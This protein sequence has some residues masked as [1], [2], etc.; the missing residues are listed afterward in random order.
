MDRHS[1]R[2]EDLPPLPLRRVRDLDLEESTDERRSPH[3]S[4][5]SGIVRR[6]SFA[7][8][9]GDD[10]LFLA[11]FDL[12]GSE[13]GT[14]HRALEGELPSDEQERKAAK[15]DLE[16]LTA[17][18]PMEGSPHGGLLGLGSGSGEGRHRGFFWALE[19]DG[20]L[21]G[22]PVAIELEPLYERLGGEVGAVN[23][24][25]AA[26]LGNRL[27]LFN[28]GNEE[29]SVNAIA[30]VEVAD[31]SQSVCGDRELDADELASVREYEL[32]EVEG[33][34]LCF[35]DATAPLEDVIVFTASAEGERDGD[36]HGS[37]LGTVTDG[38]EVRRLR[39]IDPS[40]KVEGVHAAVDAGVVDLVFVCDQDDPE[41]PS[42][43]LSATMPLDAR[44][45]R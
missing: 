30:E 29:G 32:G 37:L 31:L 2:P 26:V 17:L 41:T 6:G 28:R 25:G 4:A 11:A 22:D 33:V 3:L 13:P 16:A 7:Y 38:G 12:T 1:A 45:E 15:P 18:P 24:E 5:A 10:E 27:W 35:S 21:H 9:I 36:I 34:P 19:A 40:W 39:S 14:V 8:V 44:F 20:S 23:V 42:P 43:L